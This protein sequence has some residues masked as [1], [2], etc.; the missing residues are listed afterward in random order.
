M[1]DPDMTRDILRAAAGLVVACK[2]AGPLRGGQML[3]A[4]GDFLTPQ[5]LRAL[6]DL[7]VTAGALRFDG[8]HYHYLKD[9]APPK[10]A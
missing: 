10:A 2:L 3:E 4:V 6:L 1:A 9:L 7:A 5:Q 8:L